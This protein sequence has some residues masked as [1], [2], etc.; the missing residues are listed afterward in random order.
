MSDESA[1]RNFTSQIKDKTNNWEEMP[2]PNDVNELQE[3]LKEYQYFT[4]SKG[5]NNKSKEKKVHL[6]KCWAKLESGLQCKRKQ[7]NGTSF[8]KEHM[9]HGHLFGTISDQMNNNHNRN[10]N[11]SNNTDNS[12][13]SNNSNKKTNQNIR[14]YT[15]YIHDVNGIQ[16]FADEARNVYNTESVL[17]ENLEP[18]IIGTMNGE[19]EIVINK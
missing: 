9:N 16:Y 12:N 19:N 15:F 17:S 6:D 11:N 4:K 2:T 1:F 5:K 7:K 13:N 3:K 10:S 18:R 14:T 8:C